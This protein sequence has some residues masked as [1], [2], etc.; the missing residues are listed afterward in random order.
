MSLPLHLEPFVAQEDPALELALHT[1]KLPYPP[2]QGYIKTQELCTQ[3][4][5]SLT[6]KLNSVLHSSSR[7]WC[8]RAW[9]HCRLLAG[10]Y[11]QGNHA[12]LLW[13]HPTDSRAE[14]TC[15]QTACDRHWWRHH[16]ITA[17]LSPIINPYVLY[18][19]VQQSE[20]TK[21][22]FTLLQLRKCDVYYNK[23]IFLES[24]FNLH[25]VQNQEC[26]QNPKTS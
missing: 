9:K 21:D 4:T 19:L 7:W 14:P 11:R 2:E 23:H 26:F 10:V 22:H 8:S 15:N 13:C 5:K 6:N 12:D 3:T 16:Y 24:L 17:P 25:V 1:G 20:A 18:S